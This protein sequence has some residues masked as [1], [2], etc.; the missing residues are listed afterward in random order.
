MA[1]YKRAAELGAGCGGERAQEIEQT[2]PR[3]RL[4]LAQ[5]P[6]MIRYGMLVRALRQ[7]V[8]DGVAVTDESMALERIGH[9]P[10]LLMGAASNI[11][12]TYPQDLALAAWYL[13]NRSVA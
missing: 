4:W 6:Q 7:A 9:K 2:V 8:E 10:M 13:A 3:E 11:K 1:Q 12:V 5:T